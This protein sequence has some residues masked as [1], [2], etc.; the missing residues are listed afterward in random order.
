[1]STLNTNGEN[2]G[3]QTVTGNDKNNDSE[4]DEHDLDKDDDHDI[5]MNGDENTDTD[6][7]TEKVRKKGRRRSAVINDIT[8]SIM[9]ET[10]GVIPPLPKK[11]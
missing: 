5:E 8:E 2:D 10:E 11:N 4:K 9:D 7:D 1:G 3:K 6:T